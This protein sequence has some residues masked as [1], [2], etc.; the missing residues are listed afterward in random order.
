M[1]SVSL[2]LS[3]SELRAVLLGST[4]S[5]KRFVGNTILGKEALDAARSTAPC[6]KGEGVVCGR[7]VTLVDSPGWWKELNLSDTAALV[8]DGV[9][10]LK[11][12]CSTVSLYAPLDPMHS[13]LWL[14]WTCHS[15]MPTEDQWRIKSSSLARESEVTP[16]YCS[17]GRTVWGRQPL[18]SSL[19]VK[20]AL[21]WLIQKYGRR[22]LVLS[23]EDRGDGTQVTGLLHKTEVMVTGN[24][25][26]HFEIETSQLQKVEKERREVKK[27]AQERFLRAQKQR[28][29]LK[30]LKG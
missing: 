14:R 29:T 13:A 8:K 4:R 5:G 10:L 19:K 12:D 26:S 21:Q 25:G 30:A 17:H 23:N 15:L 22:Y 7:K 27:R 9:H 24:S 28:K 6:E 20:E 18:S 1:A 16:S 11:M 2:S 3:L